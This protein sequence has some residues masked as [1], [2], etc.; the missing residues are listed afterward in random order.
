MKKSAI[1]L[2][3]IFLLAVLFPYFFIFAQ[4]S[5]VPHENPATTKDS[6]ELISVALFYSNVF[7]LAA[8]SQYQDAQT[9]LKELEYA[10]IPD[11]LRYITARYNSLCQQL[12]TAQDNLESLLDEASDLLSHYQTGD[13]QQKLDAAEAAIISIQLLQEDIQAVTNTLGNRLGVST[14]LAGSQIR[15]T[16]DRLEVSLSRPRQLVTELAQ[17][18]Q[19][20]T[21]EVKFEVKGKIPTELS[22]S[23]IPASVF[24]GD[25]ITALGKLTA[26]NKALSN[27]KLTFLLDDEPLVITT[28][29]SDGSYS[30]DITIPYKADIT[31]PYKYVSTMT[32]SVAYIPAGDD[33]GNYLGCSQPV[34]VNTSFYPTYLEV[35]APETASPGL[36][37]TISG[38]VSS[39]GGTVD[40]LVRVLL[41]DT[42]LAEEVTQ[43]KFS[44]KITPPPQTSIGEHSLILV[45]IP[46]ERYC[47]TSE[48]VKINISRLPMQADIRMP[49][50]IVTPK[51]IQISGKIYDSLG[52]VQGAGVSFVFRNSS[53]TVKTSNDGGFT[54]SI[55]MPLDL[56]SVGPQELAITIEP[57][58]LWNAPLEI[59][60]QIFTINWVNI[61]LMLVVCLSLGLVLYARVKTK[62]LGPQGEI[63][64][65]QA[66]TPGVLTIAPLPRPGYEFTG[67]RGRI[68]S[69]YRN[70]LGAVE[71]ATGISMAPHATLREFLH[72]VTPRLL[73]TIK[74][75]TELTTITEVAL[76]SAY[77]LDLNSATGAE[78][79]TSVIKEEL[80]SE[81]T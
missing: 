56:S 1:A 11:E 81:A 65:P 54:T 9:L 8:I 57:A 72:A 27:R 12:L 5:H 62:P 77:E 15:Q 33:I 76:Y 18:R 66:A 24:V 48:S 40:R 44:L 73:G 35:L 7:N 46:G 67:I 53:T 79:L 26:N 61:G 41:D 25:S 68:F 36:S 28:T 75:F 17:L 20:L 3:L 16:Y 71:K 32:L 45:I 39:T 69:A 34:V 60:K 42:Q 80:H 47:G 37:F 59:K 23:I 22:L 19:N 2:S 29:D 38:Q 58:Q 51:Q 64:M 70:G 31:I 43:G 55:E 30:A 14:A 63:G 49:Q 6:P 52:P 74:S 21:E 50:L 13:A 4:P 10:S 78:Q